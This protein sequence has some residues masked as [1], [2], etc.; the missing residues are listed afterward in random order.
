MLVIDNIRASETTHDILKLIYGFAIVAEGGKLTTVHLYETE[1]S[2]NNGLRVF[3]H[4]YKLFD[5]IFL[6]FE[7]PL[8]FY[9]E[10][11]RKSI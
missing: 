7:I 11:A 10:N 8:G 5:R 9:L 2:R 1:Q 4:R 3:K 6:E